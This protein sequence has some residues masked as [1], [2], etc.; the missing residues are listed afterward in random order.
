MRHRVA[1]DIGGTFIEPVAQSPGKPFTLSKVLSISEDLVSG[2]GGPADR[3]PETVVLT[4]S[5]STRRRH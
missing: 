2:L 4:A 1:I 5:V 3:S